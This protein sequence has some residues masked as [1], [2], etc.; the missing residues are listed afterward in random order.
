MERGIRQI[1]FLRGWWLMPTVTINPRIIE[2]GSVHVKCDNRRFG[3]QFQAH[4]PRCHGLHRIH[5]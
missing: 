1:G 2:Q 4:R 3:D 5:Y